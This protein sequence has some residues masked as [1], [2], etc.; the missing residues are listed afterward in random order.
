[1]YKSIEG[2]Y[3]LNPDTQIIMSLIALSEIRKYRF[4]LEP[5]DVRII[6]NNHEL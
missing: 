1:M 3:Y 5:Y 6:A 4:P 2:F